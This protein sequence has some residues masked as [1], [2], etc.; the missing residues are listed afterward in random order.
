MV[1]IDLHTYAWI[2]L[3][4][5]LIVHVRLAVRTRLTGMRNM[6]ITTDKCRSPIRHNLVFDLDLKKAQVAG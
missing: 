5:T 4:L 3:A 2:P 1:A 6:T